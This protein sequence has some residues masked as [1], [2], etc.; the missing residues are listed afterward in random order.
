MS[1]NYFL[2]SLFLLT[3]LVSCGGG[4]GGG[5]GESNGYSGGGY[6]EPT[7]TAPTINN[8]DMNI[9]VQ[10]NQTSAF[11]VNA[12]DSNGDTLT[13]SLSGDDSSLLSIST[14][15]LVTFNTAPD[16][17]DPSDAD[18]NNI[19]KITASVS[20]GSLSASKNFEV[21]VTN[22]T[23]DDITTN[24]FDGV[25]IR[26]GYIQSATVCMAV[27]D[28][29]GDDTCEGATYSTTTNVDGSF[30]LKI[31][32]NVTAT[33]KLLAEDGF[34]PVTDDADSFTMG[35]IDPTTEQ[36]LVISPLSTMLYVDNRF[37]YQS[38]KEKLGID[39]NFMI[40][41][42]DPYL[43]VNDSASNKAALVNTQLLIM[44]ESLSVLQS[45]SGASD[46]TA[47]TIINNAI[48]DRD[49]ATETSLGDTTLVRDILL[50]LDLPNYTVTNEQLENLSGSFSS[51]LQ[52]IY[53]DSNNEQSY[54]SMTARDHVAPLL[55]GILDDTADSSEIDQIIFNTLQWVSD[56]S[57][58]TNLT[59]VE[60]F[61][62]TSYTIGNSGSAYYTVD[63]INA[64]STALVIY[65]RIGDTI[66]FE[67]TANSVFTAHPFEISTAQ[68]DTAGNN[69]IGSSEG[70][71]QSNNT[72]TVTADTPT[73]LYPHCGVHSGM[74]TNGKIEIVTTFDQS[75]IDINQ[76]SGALE[77]NG[78]VSLGPYKGASGFTHKVYLRTAAAGDSQH[79]HEFNEYPGITF[80]MPPEQGYHG[81]STSSGEPRF[82]TKSHY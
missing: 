5:G 37:S 30:S 69:N 59:D 17:E 76:A 14:S 57:S 23:S 64:D 27:T 31:D 40:R 80:Y 46:L 82:K 10:E 38:L 44:Y 45:Q 11:T 72:L 13:Y 15:G 24:N 67:P 25:L 22:D 81:Q 55:K 47:V 63:G 6:G 62:T 1:K 71:S 74:Y 4:G 16:Y 35:L 79:A 29:D 58:R 66:V 18:I 26:D 54:F 3:I 49:A 73:I 70:W 42:D 19:Y 34:N 50:N 41:F 12:S 61:R 7:N 56:K 51:F 75:K 32:D 52:K 36:N 2:T 65:A 43:S 20:D 28:A 78:T 77:V 8:T 21:T 9:S 33:I 53:V 48:F 60:D 68:N 39:S